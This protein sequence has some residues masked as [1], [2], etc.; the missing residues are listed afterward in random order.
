[1]AWISTGNGSIGSGGP[2]W[3]L[4]TDR[5]QI[6]QSPSRWSGA[7][8]SLIYTLSYTGTSYN[9]K[10]N[11]SYQFSTRMRDFHSGATGSSFSMTP[12]W[13]DTLRF[14]NPT[15]PSQSIAFASS[16]STY[17]FY[18][19]SSPP[20]SQNSTYYMNYKANGTFSSASRNTG[21]LGL[22]ATEIDFIIQGF[23]FVKRQTHELNNVLGT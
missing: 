21:I 10:I 15:A 23:S 12:A 16:A 20:T 19:Y 14:T 13:S 4:S 9:W 7:A 6:N 5:M 18:H 11:K 22:T 8:S 3:V 1:M 2:D 17:N